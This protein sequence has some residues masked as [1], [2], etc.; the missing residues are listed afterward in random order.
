[1]K[2]QTQE[3]KGPKFSEQQAQNMITRRNLM[4]IGFMMDEKMKRMNGGENTKE[5]QNRG[6]NTKEEQN[7]GQNEQLKIQVDRDQPIVED[8]E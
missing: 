3:Y 7:R 2:N 4:N 1:M 6:Q 5:E 8:D